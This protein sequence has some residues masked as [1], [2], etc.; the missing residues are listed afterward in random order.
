MQVMH[1]ALVALLTYGNEPHVIT[2]VT[3]REKGSDAF[4]DSVR[5]N[6]PPETRTRL[7]LDILPEIDYLSAMQE[8]PTA[9]RIAELLRSRYSDSIWWIHNYHIGKNPLF[10]EAFLQIA[11]EYP[12]QKMVFH[13]HDF[14]ESGRFANLEALHEMV[15]H[16]LYPVAPNVRYAVINT[17]DRDILSS[18]GVPEELIF[19][20]NNPVAAEAPPA[21][22]AARQQELYSWASE[23]AHH[24][25]EEGLF[26]VYPVRTIR[27]KNV[28]EAALAVKLLTRPVNL[29]VTLPGTSPQ[30]APYSNLVKQCFEEG[31]IP[32][33]WGIGSHLEE[34]GFSFSEL[35]GSSDA[36][37]SSAV[38]EGFGYLFIDAVR[39]KVP[40]LARK[41]DILQGIGSLFDNYPAG[42]YRGLSVPLEQA[43]ATELSLL[44]RDALEKMRSVLSPARIDSL[45]YEVE[46]FLTAEH[47]DFSYLSVDMQRRILRKCSESA[48]IETLRGYNPELLSAGEA[49]AA[50]DIPDKKEE[51]DR[52]FGPAAHAA[53]MEEITAS[54]EY[55]SAGAVTAVHSSIKEAGGIHERILSRFSGPEYM[56]I[57]YFQ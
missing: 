17:R 30:E 49:L 41:L 47:I 31:L 7:Q 39:H 48:Y 23:H 14:P 10:T 28:L 4:I 56:R 5:Q 3:G 19:L 29:G 53:G 34:A 16:P 55:P 54:F 50:G 6:L 2:V 9:N 1:E 15:R 45:Q 37:V 36:M 32:G 20:L 21:P 11:A 12:Q 51:I 18:A 24:W 27:R 57:L 52:R 43:D 22:S 26:C 38:Q 42:F 35:L 44:Y 46:T 13:I 40:L 25:E 8:R 33:V